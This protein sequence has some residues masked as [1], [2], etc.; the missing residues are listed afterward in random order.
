[1]AARR[2]GYAALAWSAAA[3]AAIFAALAGFVRVGGEHETRPPPPSVVWM[4][5]FQIDAPRLSGPADASAPIEASEPIEASGVTG[6][7]AP[8]APAAPAASAPREPAAA[9]DD[10]RAALESLPSADDFAPPPSVD[11]PE[12]SRRIDDPEPIAEAEPTPERSAADD[13][14]PASSESDS[15]GS[16]P[17]APVP[18]AGQD[19]RE[20]TSPPVRDER[21]PAYV[22]TDEDLDEAWRAALE[23]SRA[24][25][26]YPSFSLDDV[27]PAPRPAEPGP[28]ESVFERAEEFGSA[29]RS[30]MSPG[31]ARSH[32]GQRLARLC[33]ALTGGF[34]LMGLVAFCADHQE[35]AKL[36]A[37]L[38]P[39]YLRARPEC[40]EVD[41]PSPV[42]DGGSAVNCR[43]VVDEQ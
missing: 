38:K 25:R 32:F 12:P 15:E 41:A 27:V 39:A 6:A 4:E 17:D 23:Q 16:A 29:P 11:G 34:G 35:T 9:S 43:L 28:A 22:V 14:P 5:A 3:H 40:V 37:H 7:S 21:A 13:V 42:A 2:S 8:A 36:F 20:P 18:A 30:V 24:Q 33:N 26:E 10:E 31:K 19:T 1:M